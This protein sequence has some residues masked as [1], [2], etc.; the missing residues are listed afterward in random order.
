MIW[1]II[2]PSPYL[3]SIQKVPSS[4][5][6]ISVLG[7]PCLRGD[8][9][10]CCL[11]GSLAIPFLGGLGHLLDLLNPRHSCSCRHSSSLR[12]PDVSDRNCPESRCRVLRERRRS[13]QGHHEEPFCTRNF[14][15]CAPSL[16]PLAWGCSDQSPCSSSSITRYDCRLSQEPSGIIAALRV[17][18]N[19]NKPHPE[20]F[21]NSSIV[22][23]N[24]WQ[25]NIGNIFI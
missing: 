16:P 19:N 20:M 9:C 13:A 2:L 4:S 3:P 25:P 6:H 18:Q 7:T 10:R 23:P 22:I 12:S 15:A 17:K 14:P 21:R 1:I 24:L 8:C 11:Y 5:P